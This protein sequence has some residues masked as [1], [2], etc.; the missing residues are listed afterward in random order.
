MNPT[1]NYSHSAD[2]RMWLDCG[3]HGCVTLNRIT[4]K[5]VV[6]RTPRDIPPCLADLVVTVDGRMSRSRVNLVS[7]FSAKWGAALVL[8][9]NNVAPF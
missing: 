9:A 6:S 5:L 7:G 1:F 4:P 3:E 2:V 8:P